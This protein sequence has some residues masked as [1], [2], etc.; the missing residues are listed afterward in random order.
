MTGR[1]RADPAHV[2]AFNDEALVACP[3]CGRRAVARVRVLPEPATAGMLRAS[4]E[5]SIVCPHCG[6]NARKPV[7][8]QARMAP[9]LGAFDGDL[10]LQTPCCGETLWAYN[11]HHL[12]ALEAFV[13]AP[14]RERRPDP[15]SGWSNRSWTSRLPRWISAAKH[16]DEVLKGIARLRKRLEET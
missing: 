14:L 16:R 5:G 2:A 9:A 6:H 11:A 13:R 15:E 10:W 4:H 3:A 12:D 8:L 7:F 1:H